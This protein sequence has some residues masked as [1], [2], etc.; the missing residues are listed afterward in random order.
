MRVV[1]PPNRKRLAP[2]GLMKH[3]QGGW[4]HLIPRHPRFPALLIPALS[5]NLDARNQSRPP[6]HFLHDQ[7]NLKS[8]GKAAGGYSPVRS[9]T[10]PNGCAPCYP[11]AY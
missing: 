6:S 10:S 3:P 2:V 4:C 5:T 11:H 8:R 1:S 9:V 7:H